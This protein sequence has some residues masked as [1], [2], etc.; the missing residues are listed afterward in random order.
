MGKR[1]CKL[2][3]EDFHETQFKDFVSLVNHPKFVCR[4][5]GHVANEDDILCKPRKMKVKHKE[6][7]K[8]KES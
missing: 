5:C 4:K 7:N 6:K 1:M 8:N 2:I 3:K